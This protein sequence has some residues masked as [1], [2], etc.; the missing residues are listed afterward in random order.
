MAWVTITNNP[1]WQYDNSPPDPGANS[2]LRPLWLKQTNG[3]RTTNGHA[4]YT[5][6]R[7]TIA[8]AG[9]VTFAVTV[10]N[11][12]S[13]NKYYIDSGGPAPTVS[14]IEGRTYKFDQSASSNSNHPLR[15]SS[16]PNGIHASGSE[17]TTGVT[18]SGTPGSAGAYTQ[19]VVA[20]SA[21]TLYYYCV[22][23]SNMGGTANT[24]ASSTSTV[25]R[26]EIS[27]TFWDNVS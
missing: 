3:I 1:S 4:V 22:N 24:P 26:G 14:L 25:S 12:G 19:I 5:S 23:H 6:V 18:T 8:T 13:G 7:K 20:T 27:K 21:P 11:P 16:T 9:T 15:F 10:S 2:P 17:Y